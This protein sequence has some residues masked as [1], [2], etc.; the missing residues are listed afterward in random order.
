MKRK[1][2]TLAITNLFWET[3]FFSVKFSLIYEKKNSRE[4]VKKMYHQIGYCFFVWL[5]VFYVQEKKNRVIKQ[6]MSFF[7]LLLCQAGVKCRSHQFPSLGKFRKKK[8]YL[9]KAKKI[10]KLFL[11]GNKYC[12]FSPYLIINRHKFTIKVEKRTLNKS[13]S[14]K[15]ERIFYF[16]FVH[17]IN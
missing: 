11:A 12:I 17:L 13:C 6:K 14:Y 7:V 1:F 3:I 16:N 4:S 9:K 15:M 2:S 8:K 10:V 5:Q